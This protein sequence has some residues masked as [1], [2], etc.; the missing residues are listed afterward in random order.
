MIKHNLRFE[1]S[2]KLKKTLQLSLLLYA[3]MTVKLV[4][5][6]LCA[7][8]LLQYVTRNSDERLSDEL[9][10]IQNGNRDPQ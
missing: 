4:S 2:K 5:M 8:M 6:D 9:E 7:N 1:S 3:R 10:S